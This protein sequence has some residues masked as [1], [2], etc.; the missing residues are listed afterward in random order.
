MTD[1][2]DTTA[3]L[4]AEYN[5]VAAALSELREKFADVI[6]PVTTK[7]G[8][9]DAKDVRG[10]LVKLRTGLETMRKEIKEPAL[11]RTQAIDAEAKAITAAIKAIEE[12]IDA[13]IKVEENRIEAEKAAKA[14]RLAEIRTKIDGIR[15][16]PFAL[17]GASSDEIGAE[18]EALEGFIP[19]EDV[20]GELVEDCKAAIAEAGEA[21]GD[22]YARVMGQEAAAAMVEAQRLQLEE[23]AKAERAAMAA[24]REAMEAERAAFAAERAEFEAMK[25]AA[26]LSVAQAG[27]VTEP[28]ELE[29]DQDVMPE[30]EVS[31]AVAATIFKEADEAAPVIDWHIRQAA[32]HTAE[33]FEAMAG[34]VN[35]CGFFK[36]AGELRAVAQNL[37]DG[38]LDSALSKADREALIAADTL[39]LDAT[40]ECIDA[41]TAQ[42][43]VA[44]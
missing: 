44:A 18:K 17:A 31:P 36:F 3:N 11:R 8:M 40:V 16:L 24:Q 37:R 21:L 35:V 12:P 15:N 2:N 27:A 33:Q 5:P 25:A 26:V 43:Q 42:E 30:V 41:L 13:Q 9:K 39:L 7:E 4:I 22:L 10:K 20:F 32:M 6:F 38:E 1:T 29:S 28:M 23:A 19:L 14:A 34:K